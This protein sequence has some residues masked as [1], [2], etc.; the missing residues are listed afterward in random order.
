[1]FALL[2]GARAIALVLV[3]AL[4]APLWI[5]QKVVERVQH[6]FE[7]RQSSGDQE[8][9]DSAQ[10]RLD[11]W[12]ALP[13]IVAES[14]L[15]G[16]GFRSFRFMWANYAHDGLPKAAHSTWVEFLAEEGILGIIAYLWLLWLLGIT[17]FRVW[18]D[19]GGGIERDVALGMTCAICCLALLDTT[20]TRFRNREVMAYIWILGGVLARFLV[21]RSRRKSEEGVGVTQLATTVSKA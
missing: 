15:L 2:R 21:E 6:T 3:V 9:E 20:G 13:E 14:P 19:K 5:P 17:A 4:S 8:L 11:Q 12:K 16:H 7:G 18:R 10:V 1:V